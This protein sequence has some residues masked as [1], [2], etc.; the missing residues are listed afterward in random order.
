[1]II[2][3]ILLAFGLVGIP[4]LICIHTELTC[5]DHR[6]TRSYDMFCGDDALCGSM[7]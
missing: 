3:A 4:A 1:M 2:N 6:A 7:A 5:G